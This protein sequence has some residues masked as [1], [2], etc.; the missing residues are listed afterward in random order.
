MAVVKVTAKGQITIPVDIRS[1]IG[2]TEDTYL[3]VSTEGNEVCLRKVVPI[4][5][6][7]GDD[8]VWGLI[9]TGASG[10]RDISQKHDRY[11]AEGEWERWHESS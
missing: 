11:L 3:E 2:I 9:G 8:P 6:L 4:R 1:A 7:S 5:P 10:Q